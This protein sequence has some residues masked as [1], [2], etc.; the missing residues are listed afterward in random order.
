[1]TLICDTPRLVTVF[2]GSGFLGRHVVRLLARR[3]HRVR[4]AVRR[5]D[6]AFHLQPLGGV[7][8]IVPVQANLR[9]R[10]SVERAVAGSDTV[11]NL[12][13]IFAENGR[14]T[15]AAVHAFGA[16][17]VAEAARADGVCRLVHVSAIGADANAASSFA[18]SKAAGEAA[19]FE[20]MA[21]AV[22][23]RP[24]AMFGPEDRFFNLIAGLARLS[25]VLP[26]IGGGETL[27]QPVYVGDVAEAV[28]R[29]AN[30]A[31]RA[32]A[33]YE[34]GGPEV[35]TLA[36]CMRRVLAETGRRRLL[37]RLSFAAAMRIARIVGAIP[38]AP[39]TPD[40]VEL[41]KGP[42][43]VSRAAIDDGRTFADLGI[44]PR[45]MAAVLPGYLYRFLPRG[46]YDRIGRTG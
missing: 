21:E 5:P 26:L 3:G 40:Q 2:G 29:A 36:D 42:G 30:G 11:I 34:L 38:G 35:V 16:R 32:G 17:A 33:V 4:V 15:H 8:Q 41:L 28:V 14:Q 13:G 20:V 1:M 22:V 43:I 25:P 45:A 12:V 39:I 9:Y 6:L 18:R 44:E 7:G 19:V 24:S 46:Q 23:I 31:A 10:D 27:L 37:V